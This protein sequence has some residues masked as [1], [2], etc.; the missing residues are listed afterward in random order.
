ML[1]VKSCQEEDIIKDLDLNDLALEDL[2]KITE[3][4]AVAFVCNC[5]NPKFFVVD[6]YRYP[7]LVPCGKCE[8]C[9]LRTRSRFII[10]L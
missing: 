10:L 2:E 7:F 4:P 5:V 8:L 9:R 6:G 3:F 1:E